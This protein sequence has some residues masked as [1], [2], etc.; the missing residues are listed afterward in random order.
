MP[1]ST[2]VRRLSAIVAADVAGY[3]RLMAADEEGTLAVLKAHRK[4]L[5]DP[6]I[7]EH[8]GHIVKTTGDGLLLEFPSVVQAVACAVAVQRGMAARNSAVAAD[9]RIEFRVGIN[10]GD[11]IVED[12]DVFGDGVNVAARLEQC[13]EPGG[14]CIS[15]D[16]YRQ[17]RGKLDLAVS[18]AGPQRLK[19]IAEPVKVYRVEAAARAPPGAPPAKRAARGARWPVAAVAGFA[20]VAAAVVATVV[21]LAAGRLAAPAPQAESTVQAQPVSGPVLPIVAVLPFANQTGDED[22]QYFAD[23]VTDELIGALG[24]FNTLRVI[25]RNAVL[26]YKNR[27]V[28]REEIKSQLGASYLVEGSVRRSDRRVRIA[29]QLTDARAA[30]VLWTDR[31]DGELADIFEFQA[32]IAREIAGRLATNI[33]QIEGRQ[34]LQQPVP[35]QDAHDLVLRARAIGFTSSRSANRKFRALMTKAMEL[36]PSYAIAPALLAEALFVHVVLGW[37][38]LPDDDLRSGEALARRAIALAPDEPDGHRALGRFL[39]LRTE[40]D[41]ARTELRRAIEINPSDAYALATW[42]GIQL[43][44]GDAPGAVDSLERALT[45]DPS[46]EAIHVFDLSVAYYFAERLEDAMGTA[47]RGLSRSPDFP[48]F[49]VVAAAAA[50]RLGLAAQAA[51]YAEEIRRRL[52]FLD[53]DTLGSRYK[54]PA[55]REYLREGLRQAGL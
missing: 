37:A 31:Y 13:A 22:Q 54:D 51:G 8:R 41:Q 21:W 1:K 34:S 26:P 25:G 52:P 24:R 40:Y 5:I 16:A 15:D 48:M 42:G 43:F 27:P 28:T 30:T 36:D 55:Y 38:A 49:N 44:G 46:L 35:N 33:T 45:Y 50:A 9:K 2:V 47:Q 19:N 10:I 32:D 12:G 6:L 14:I 7:D 11:V 4:E 39:V 20:A 29:A 3:S 18:D 53:V 23:G 17:V